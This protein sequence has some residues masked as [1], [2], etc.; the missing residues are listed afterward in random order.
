MNM[1]INIKNRK[2]PGSDGYTVEFLKFFW[3]GL[4]DQ[5]LIK[6]INFSFKIKLLS[7]TQRGLITCIS[8]PGKYKKKYI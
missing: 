4:A 5:Y 1:L 3:K 8:K 6:T 7:I 2:S